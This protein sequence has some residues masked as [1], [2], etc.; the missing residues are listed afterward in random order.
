MSE[1]E[2]VLLCVVLKYCDNCVTNLFI[3]H[4][5]SIYNQQWLMHRQHYWLTCHNMSLHATISN[6]N[7]LPI[8]QE[9]SNREKISVFYITRII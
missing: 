4:L 3:F 6:N 1:R 2:W 5:T 8:I 7:L 9:C